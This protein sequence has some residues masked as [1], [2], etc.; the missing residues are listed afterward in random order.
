ME[1][2]GYISEEYMDL[3]KFS[4]IT[5]SIQTDSPRKRIQVVE[6]RLIRKTSFLYERRMINTPEAA[7]T[8][9][10]QLFEAYDREYFYTVY[11]TVRCE[12]ICVE[13]VSIGTLTATIVSPREILRTGLLCGAFGFIIYHNHPSG[14]EIIPSKE[15]ISITKRIKDAGNLIGIRLLDHIIV[16]DIAYV[17]LNERRII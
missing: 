16:T 4:D 7:A 11:F 10:R 3:R 13:L 17:S 15:D 9:G 12:P 8:L 14:G 5:L 1:E 6:A 2:E